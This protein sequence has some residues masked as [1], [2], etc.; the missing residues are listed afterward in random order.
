M[1]MSGDDEL[2][3]NGQQTLILSEDASETT[4]YGFRDD[5]TVYEL[6]QSGDIPDPDDLFEWTTF[7]PT[8]LLTMDDQGNTYV[9]VP[10]AG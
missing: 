4:I 10:V 8:G 1:D 5:L 3:S 6:A 7:G 9:G 2:L